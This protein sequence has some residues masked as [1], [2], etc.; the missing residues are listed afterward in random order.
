MASGNIDFTLYVN[1]NPTHY[2]L[3]YEF[4]YRGTTILLGINAGDQV[5]VRAGDPLDS[6]LVGNENFLQSYFSGFLVSL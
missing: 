4:D 2:D 1:D 5:Y 3:Y 6:S